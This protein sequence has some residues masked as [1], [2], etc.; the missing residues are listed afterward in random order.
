MSERREYWLRSLIAWLVIGPLGLVI[1]FPFAVMIATALKPAAEILTPQ[2]EWFGS[3]LAFENF[4]SMWKATNF[5]P[6]LINSLFVS[7]LSTLFALAVAVPA[8]YGLARHS[9]RGSGAFRHFLLVT[10]M[11]S[12][13]VLVIGLFR[14]LASLGLI[15]NLSSVTLI[16]A[17]FN[18]TFAVWMMQSYFETVPRDLEEAAWLEGAGRIR[19]ALTVFLP[20]AA[21]AIAVT[22]LFTF[23]QT[24]NE[25]VMALTMLRRQENYTL[26]IQV[27]SLVAGRYTIEWHHVMAA[28][29]AATL[30]VA[31]LFSWLQ[32][33]MVKGLAIGSVK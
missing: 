24:W 21:P 9:F 30:P 29:F 25:F 2:A 20:L 32:G 28:A 13:I 27:F 10:Q 5:G 33:Y 4:I 22:A 1:L 12:P 16:C 23:I 19:A 31:V 14:L 11:L 7:G 17:A 18:I 3:R 8:A 26:T 6:A 15:D